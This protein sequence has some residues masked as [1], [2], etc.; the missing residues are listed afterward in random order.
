MIMVIILMYPMFLI[1]ISD[2]LYWLRGSSQVFQDVLCVFFKTEEPLDKWYFC[3][4]DFK[5]CPFL[6]PC[7]TGSLYSSDRDV[8]PTQAHHILLTLG[9]RYA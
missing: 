2:S 8:F 9:L 6:L 1:L 7:I 5:S 3:L 4:T